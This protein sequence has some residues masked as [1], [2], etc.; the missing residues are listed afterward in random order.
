MLRDAGRGAWIAENVNNR[1]GRSDFEPRW[2]SCRRRCP[3]VKRVALVGRLV[4]RRSSRRVV[5]HPPG[6]EIAEKRTQIAREVAG[7]TRSAAYVV[8]ATGDVRTMAAPDDSSVIAA[9]AALKRAW[10]GR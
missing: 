10:H 7:V 1:A 8:S 9:I 3:G 6:V 5:P 2:T 4:R